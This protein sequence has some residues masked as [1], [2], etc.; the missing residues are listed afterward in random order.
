MGSI[1][2]VVIQGNAK[3]TN[4]AMQ[5]TFHIGRAGLTVGFATPQRAAVEAMGGIKKSNS[6]S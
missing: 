3:R 1:G 5:N 4:K 2:S 6:A